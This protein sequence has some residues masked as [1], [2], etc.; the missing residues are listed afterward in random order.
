MGLMTLLHLYHVVHSVYDQG[1]Y[2][3]GTG[4]VIGAVIVVEMEGSVRGSALRGCFGVSA[5]LHQQLVLAIFSSVGTTRMRTMCSVRVGV[6][7]ETLRLHVVVM[8]F[9]V[10]ALLTNINVSSSTISVVNLSSH[11]NSHTRPIC[12]RNP[13]MNYSS[14]F[15]SYLDMRPYYSIDS[16][17]RSDT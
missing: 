12:Y 15:L 1:L 3:S 2:T 7:A 10:L 6:I 4:A 9:Q 5:Y 11:P 17:Q 16:L 14:H 13:R 8:M